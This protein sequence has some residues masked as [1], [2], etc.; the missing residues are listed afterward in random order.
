MK[1]CWRFAQSPDL[2]VSQ[3]FKAKYYHNFH[4]LDAS[5]GYK[6]SHS[7]RAIHGTIQILKDSCSKESPSEILVWKGNSS[8]LLDIK[9][10]FK[11]SRNIISASDSIQAGQCDNTNLKRF[12]TQIWKLPI[13]RKI[14]IF[15]WRGYHKGLPAGYQL[16]RRNLAGIK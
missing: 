10:A 2:L 9:S 11:V 4:I 15:I 14:K 1:Q 12:W 7:W 3:L 6:P 8:G 13:P 16:R 5:L